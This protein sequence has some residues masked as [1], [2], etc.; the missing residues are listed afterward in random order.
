MGRMWSGPRNGDFPRNHQGIVD[1]QLCWL[2]SYWTRQIGFLFGQK[3]R[4]YSEIQDETIQKHCKSLDPWLQCKV[5]SA[6]LEGGQSP[7]EAPRWSL[8]FRRVRFR[9]A[10][11]RG[12]RK[13]GENMKS[14]LLTHGFETFMWLHFRASVKWFVTF[15]CSL[16]ILESWICC[17]HSLSECL[18]CK[19]H[20]SSHQ[21]PGKKRRLIEWNL[22][23]SAPPCLTTCK[24]QQQ[25]HWHSSNVLN[26]IYES[27]RARHS[28]LHAGHGNIP[29][30]QAFGSYI[31]NH[32][33]TK[34]RPPLLGM[35]LCILSGCWT[36]SPKHEDLTEGRHAEW[37]F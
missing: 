32:P 24:F 12:Q 5:Y 7:V 31:L 33:K 28:R 1:L 8:L 34:N 14:V 9:S 36:I 19:L 22:I 37:N 23:T 35:V 17:L 25:L 21:Q 15:P 11:N 3:A 26:Q 6:R 30:S 4:I 29:S 16:M 18:S 27:T 20:S 2:A 10:G 13:H